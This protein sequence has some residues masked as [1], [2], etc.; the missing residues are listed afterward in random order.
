MS[1]TEG[2]GKAIQAEGSSSGGHLPPVDQDP[3][4]LGLAERYAPLIFFDRR[5]PFLPVVVGYAI[6]TA[7]GYS[8]SFPRCIG[9]T[10][11][12]RKPAQLAIEYEI[13]W[14]WDISHLY[15]LEHI[16]VYADEDEVVGVEGSWHG[17][18]FPWKPGREVILAGEHP[19]LYSEPGKHAFLPK[20]DWFEGY[21]EMV[22]RS[23]GPQA[24]RGGLLV[25]SIFESELAPFK[26]AEADALIAEYLR[27]RAFEPTFVFDRPFTITRDMLIPWPALR[28][29]IPKRV[30]WCLEQLRLPRGERC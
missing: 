15:E 26:T 5:E 12:G 9:L 29:W 17:G 24:G 3:A 11:V 14:D 10:P 16:W 19:V 27:H 13:W 18:Y 21:Q 23:C 6:F 8:P 25:A 4:A 28:D 7:D 20:A 2:V 30:K 1:A 22:L